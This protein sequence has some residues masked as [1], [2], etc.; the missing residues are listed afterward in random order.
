MSCSFRK[1]WVKKFKKGMPL[2]VKMRVYIAQVLT[3][4]ARVEG[5][6]VKPDSCLCTVGCDMVMKISL[7]RM[8]YGGGAE[9]SDVY[10]VLA[11]MLCSFTFGIWCF[12]YGG[13]GKRFGL[14]S[15]MM[16]GVY[17]CDVDREEA[18]AIVV[19]VC[20]KQ[21]YMLDSL[22][23]HYC[24][25]NVEH[26]LVLLPAKAISARTAKGQV[27]LLES[28][29]MWRFV[30]IVAFLAFYLQHFGIFV[31][32]PPPS[33]FFLLSLDLHWHIASECTTK[34]LCWNCREPG[35]MAGNCPNEG[36]CH[37]CGKGGHR[38]RD[39]TA[40]PL[41]PGDLRLCNNCYK[42]GH[43][44]A[45]CTN[46]KACNNCRKTGHLAR[47][48]PNEPICNMCNV[49]G[50]VARQCP[51]G[52]ILGD[53]RGASIRGGGGSGYRDI[54]CRNCQQLGHM[55]RD[56]MGPLMICHNC[57]GRGHLA[58]ECPSG[59]FMDRYSRRY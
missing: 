23:L 37:T 21:V 39:C 12:L 27:I 56:C 58:Y 35:H 5:S 43:F 25:L 11:E 30:T 57:G 51:K 7:R 36:I 15:W 48:C 53:H 4:R 55:S 38:A 17:G 49:S 40:P 31:T 24:L 18:T 13:Y 8:F 9:C 28:A 16:M 41:P 26:I 33:I 22:T 6:V 44:A 54:V 46:D 10:L 50:H 1:C 59:R 47:D 14:Y 34:A 29:P 3:P 2:M 42:Q 32:L 19:L 20:G 45:D 52:N